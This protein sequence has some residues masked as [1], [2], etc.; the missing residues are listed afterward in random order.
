MSDDHPELAGYEPFEEKPL[1]GQRF[2]LLLRVVVVLAVLG[3]ILPGVFTTVSVGTRNAQLACDYRGALAVPGAPSYEA[4]F[5]LF[6]PGVIG[7]ECYALDQ[8]GKRIHVDSMG[9]IPVAPGVSGPRV[10]TSNS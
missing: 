6:G 10:P 7:W 8:L 3:L 4:T 2:S 9:F 5:E 1:R